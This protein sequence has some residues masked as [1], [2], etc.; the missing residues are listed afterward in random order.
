MNRINE[1]LQGLQ[2]LMEDVCQ[3]AGGDNT[4]TTFPALKELVYRCH[5]ELQ[6]LEQTLG[7]IP[8]RQGHMQALFWPLKE[9]DVNK[10]VENLVK[11]QHLLMSALSMDQTYVTSP[12]FDTVLIF[13]ADV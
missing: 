12:S 2:K 6:S 3:L 8:E 7:I 13:L 10:A 11:L 9:A 4:Q 1:E 5:A